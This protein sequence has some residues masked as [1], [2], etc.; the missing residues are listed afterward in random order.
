MTDRMTAPPL[1]ALPRLTR[2]R[3]LD[4]GRVVCCACPRA[5]RSAPA[6]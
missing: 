3:A 5:R 6:R 4:H 1:P 2:D